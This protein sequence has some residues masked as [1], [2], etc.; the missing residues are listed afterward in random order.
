MERTFKVDQQLDEFDIPI[1]DFFASKPNHTAFIVGAFIFSPAREPTTT[2]TDN[3][4]RRPPRALLLRRAITDSLGGLWEGPGGSCDDTDATVLDSVARE[5]YEETG[6]HVSRIRDLVAVDQWDRVKG[7][8]HT[9]AIK[10]TFWVDVHEARDAP[11]WENQ[12]KLAPS[13][14]EQYR[15]VTEADVARYLAG[16]EEAIK[17]T[18]PVAAKNYLEAFAVYNRVMRVY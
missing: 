16:Q 8:E 15:W 3:E 2:V 13:E 17:F 11:D 5:V 12:I 6:L 14:H 1:I 9:K 7:G 10:F 4:A 18:F